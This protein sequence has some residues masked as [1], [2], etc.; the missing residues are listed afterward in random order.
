[1]VVMHSLAHFRY[2]NRKDALQSSIGLFVISNTMYVF[3]LVGAIGLI[4]GLQQRFVNKVNTKLVNNSITALASLFAIAFVFAIAL[5]VCSNISIRRE[6]KEKKKDLSRIGLYPTEPSVVN[7][8]LMSLIFWWCCCGGPNINIF[9]NNEEGLNH[10]CGSLAG[11]GVVFAGILAVSGSMV[12]YLVYAFKTFRKIRKL[13]A[14]IEETRRTDEVI[15]EGS[16]PGLS[17]DDVQPQSRIYHDQTQQAGSY[18]PYGYRGDTPPP[19]APGYSTYGHH[20]DTPPP[21]APGL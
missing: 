9:S 15:E 17:A 12:G 8:C 13:S 18:F 14:D 19:Y 2:M 6:E 1:M 11:F 10:D 20:G 5:M 7:D 16:S 4:H 3:S 21:Y